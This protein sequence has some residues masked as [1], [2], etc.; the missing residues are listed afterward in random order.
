MS[1]VLLDEKGTV[2]YACPKH[3]KVV[4]YTF[5]EM[6]GKYGGRFLTPEDTFIAIRH[7]RM[8]LAGDVCAEGATYFSPI[9]KDRRRLRMKFTSN[10]ILISG[11]KYNMLFAEE[12]QRE[13]KESR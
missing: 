6:V 7:N 4:G 2:R 3:L 12:L 1:M 11:Q 5:D 9:R 13:K 10:P 8:V